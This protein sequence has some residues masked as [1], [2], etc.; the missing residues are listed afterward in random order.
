LG[1]GAA[2]VQSEVMDRL[3]TSAFWQEFLKLST[4]AVQF[5]L[6]PPFLFITFSL[7][8]VCG[9]LTWKSRRQVCENSTGLINGLAA[10]SV[11]FPCLITLAIFGAAETHPMLRYTPFPQAIALDSFLRYSSL[12]VGVYWIYRMRGIRKLAI[13]LVLIFQWILLGADFIAGMAITG[14]W[15]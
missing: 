3:L 7:V 5:L 1:G 15:I 10:Q 11:F 8:S 2:E 4:W 14:D 9:I 6:I 13:S 12:L